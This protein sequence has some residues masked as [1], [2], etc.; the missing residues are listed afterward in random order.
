M[1]IVLLAILLIITLAMIGVILLQRSEGG[2]LGVGGG[3]MGGLMTTRGTADLLTRTTAILATSFMIICIILAILAGH[4]RK[5]D[6][7]I[8]SL[9]ASQTNAVVTPAEEASPTQEKTPSAPV[10]K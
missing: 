3:N 1:Q 9:E 7:I 4:S 6:S 2:G 5:S 10:S 8:N